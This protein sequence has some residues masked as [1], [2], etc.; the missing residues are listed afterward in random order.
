VTA[1]VG[2][3]REETGADIGNIRNSET[4]SDAVTY[5]Q[6]DQR[7]AHES[8]GELLPCHLRSNYESGKSVQM[9]RVN[10]SPAQK[11]DVITKYIQG[12]KLKQRRGEGSGSNVDFTSSF[13]FVF[14]VIITPSALG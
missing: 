9:D 5:Q 7:E 2:R 12:I 13:F 11:S 14:V 8:N 6:R 1:A 4:G 3:R 10:S